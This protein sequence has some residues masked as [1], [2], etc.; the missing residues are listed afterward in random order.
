MQRVYPAT[1][2]RRQPQRP[3]KHRLFRCV[4]CMQGVSQSRVNAANMQAPHACSMRM[5]C[6]EAKGAG[7]L[8]SLVCHCTNIQHSHPLS[9][10]AHPA[11]IDNPSIT[12]L[13]QCMTEQKYVRGAMTRAMLYLQVSVRCVYQC[14]V[15]VCFDSCWH[16][17]HPAL[18]VGLRQVSAVSVPPMFLSCVDAFVLR[19][20]YSS[21]MLDLQVCVMVKPLGGASHCRIALCFQ[22][23]VVRTVGMSASCCT[24]GS[25]PGGFGAMFNSVV[26]VH[27]D[28]PGLCS[29]FVMHSAPR[30]AH[31]TFPALFC[32]SP[33]LEALAPFLTSPSPNRFHLSGAVARPSCLWCALSSTHSCPAPAP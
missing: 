4:R 25:P 31:L 9:S 8:L 6:W 7:R 23:V 18:P 21:A 19:Q 10:S 11:E 1:H 20:L 16:G 3:R 30:Q 5:H 29:L 13:Q 27:T 15:P 24:C 32:T 17:P 33:H 2:A 14:L 26:L 12:V 22:N 28:R